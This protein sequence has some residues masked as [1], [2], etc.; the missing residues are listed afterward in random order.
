MSWFDDLLNLQ[1]W[2]DGLPLPR[3]QVVNVTFPGNIESGGSLV[4]NPGQDRHDLTLPRF[5]PHWQWFMTA[6][7][8]VN[9]VRFIRP[10]RDTYDTTPIVS[11]S[12]LVPKAFTPRYFGWQCA[13]TALADAIAFTIVKN[14]TATGV[15]LNIPAA[16][17]PGIGNIF[18]G[19]LS[20]S[21][22]AGDRLGVQVLQAGATAQANW[23][24]QLVLGG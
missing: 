8:A 6:A 20:V 14:G 22:A 1:F 2:K 12:F 3:R 15:V 7:P 11:Q 24:A 10:Y 23:H 17:P 13:G 9:A 5:R 4:D 16:S 21:F 18:T 19:A